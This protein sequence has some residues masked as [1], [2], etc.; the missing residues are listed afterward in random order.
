[1]M[2]EVPVSCVNVTNPSGKNSTDGIVVSRKGGTCTPYAGDC[3]RI[4]MCF[5]LGVLTC[6]CGDEAEVDACVQGRTCDALTG[7]PCEERK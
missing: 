6:G 7:I 5:H 1:M 4:S 3:L 2:H